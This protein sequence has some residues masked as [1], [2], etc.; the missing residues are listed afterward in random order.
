RGL[1]IAHG[2]GSLMLNLRGRARDASGVSL[3]L[4]STYGQGVAGDPSR[5][6]LFTGES[7]LAVGGSD[8]LFLLRGWAATLQPL[9]S[10]PIPFDELISP[11]GSTGMRGFAEGRFRGESGIVGS[12]EYRWFIAF[13]LD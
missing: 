1:R 12:A 11:S 6:V 4:G 5:H 8:R 10:A 3:A 7:V 9:G 13:D 2:G